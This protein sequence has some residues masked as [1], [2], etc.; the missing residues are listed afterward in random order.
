L[1]VSIVGCVSTTDLRISV[2]TVRFLVTISRILSDFYATR[3][4]FFRRRIALLDANVFLAADVR[5]LVLSDS[6]VFLKA[7][8][9]AFTTIRGLLVAAFVTFPSDA[10]SLIR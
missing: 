9:L 6:E 3:K 1:E 8:F 7:G 4:T 10:R 2:S 5:G